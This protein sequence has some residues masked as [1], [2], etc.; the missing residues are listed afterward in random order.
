MQG[1]EPV[2][3][4]LV[5]GDHH[6]VVGIR[7]DGITVRRI[8]LFDLF[9]GIFPVRDRRVAMEV[10]FVKATGFRKQILFHMFFLSGLARPFVIRITS[11]FCAQ[12][13]QRERRE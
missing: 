11:V 9:R 4:E 12:R 6:V 7:H 3:V 1:K 10:R 13:K 8:K 5:V 2:V